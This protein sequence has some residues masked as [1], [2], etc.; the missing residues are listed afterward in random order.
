MAKSSSL[1]SQ[2]ARIFNAA[3]PHLA[4]HGFGQRALA[5]A[6]VDC[7]IDAARAELLFPDPGRDLWRW[8]FDAV[9]AEWTPSLPRAIAAQKKI[10]DKIHAGV[11]SRFGVLAEYRAIERQA[12]KFAALPG[13]AGMA[14]KFLYQICD[15]IWRAAGDTSTDWN[16]Y[17]KRGLLVGVYSSTLLF[18]LQDESADYT[19]T[20]EFLSRRIEG[21]L[22][23]GKVKADLQHYISILPDA[24]NLAR[25]MRKPA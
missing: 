1:Q 8:F 24:F 10:R 6:A 4:R 21:V 23:I 20:G 2:R 13:N 3:R 14:A 19:A 16:F 5:L 12:V 9:Q 25:K 7:G 18:W 11:K 15:D 17:T 22:Q